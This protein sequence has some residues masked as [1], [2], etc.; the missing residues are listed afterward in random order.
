MKR[1]II[2]QGH[3]SLTLTLP[4]EW[5]K[6]MGLKGG[7]EVD[8]EADGNALLIG[9]KKDLP[10]KK[11]KLNIDGYGKFLVHYLCALYRGGVDEIELHFTEGGTIERIQKILSDYL[12]GF[13]MTNQRK[14]FCEI[15][16][17]SVPLDKEFP[18]IL[19]RFIYQL[20]IM[21]EDIC[22]ALKNQN[23]DALR[24]IRSYEIAINRFSIYCRRILN[25]TGYD[26]AGNSMLLYTTIE[27]LELIADYYKHLC[28]YFL[29][30]KGNI[31]MVGKET[32]TVACSLQKLISNYI[33]LFYQFH[34]KKAL[35]FVKQKKSVLQELLRLFTVKSGEDLRVLHYLMAIV[36]TLTH[37]YYMKL[38]LEVKSKSDLSA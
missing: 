12:I 36:E 38:S 5:S 11:I 31:K 16:N 33:D 7:D 13:E 22:D 21:A 24:D 4:R 1:K 34:E 6:K 14:N 26:I 32:A 37:V 30:F 23:I 8:V 25:K 10:I 18:T 15:K 9:A 35:N 29:V 3:D 27:G 20:Q 17:I 2:K 28:D 19:R